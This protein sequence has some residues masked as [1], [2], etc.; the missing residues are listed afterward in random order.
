MNEIRIHMHD[1]G[2]A[3]VVFDDPG[4]TVNVMT[5]DL[6]DAF[7]ANVGP[8]VDD[9]AV[10]AVV[11][12]SAK[13]DT[14]IA[15]A[16]IKLFSRVEDP[17][18]VTRIDR[19]YSNLLTRLIRGGKPVV[20]AVHGAALG[21]GMEVVLACHYILASDDPSTV[22][23]LPEVQ[24]GI[25]P[26]AG[27]TQRLTRRVGLLKGI[28]MMLAGQRVRAGK[29]LELGLVDEIA[30]AGEIIDRAM[31]VARTL[32]ESNR[33]FTERKPR[34]MDRIISLPIIRN[35]VFQKV[36]QEVLKAT[37]GCYP[38]PMKVVECVELGVRRGMDAAL[39]REISHIGN[40]FITPQCRSLVWLFLASREMKPPGEE[41]RPV[42]RAAVLGAGKMGADIASAMLAQCP[43]TVVDVAPEA[44]ESCKKTIQA[45]LDKQVTSG[46]ITREESTRR[47]RGVIA[48]GDMEAIA[49]ADL[50]IV[51][52]SEDL[53]RERRVLA[54]AEKIISDKT[55]FASSAS[56]SPLSEI[57][58]NARAPERVVGMR[59]FPPAHK[60]PLLELVNGA[61][62]DPRALE[63][64]R[65]FAMAQG[66][67][68]IQVKDAPGFYI[69]RILTPW[70]DEALRLLAEGARVEAV[71]RAMKDFGFFSGP[72]DFMDEM[73]LPAAARAFRHMNGALNHRRPHAL[74]ILTGLIEA[75]FQG[76]ENGR[77][78]Y[79]H[80]AGKKG[81]KRPNPGI[82]PHFSPPPGAP[83]TGEQ[84]QNRL[85][86]AMVN[87]AARTLQE[88]V[89]ASPADGDLGAV[90]GLGFPP[91]RAG[92]F[93]YMD[94]EGPGAVAARLQALA[95]QGAPRFRP[96]RILKDM[97]RT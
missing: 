6:L 2:V 73:G 13:P 79:I 35:M 62:V 40:L 31:E 78:F 7:E 64:A 96:A 20:A 30:P 90:L 70:L 60:A 59:Y 74:P 76:R 61:P 23:G 51:A 22:M 80:P 3:K 53:E 87:E 97:A 26:A 10:K 55:V 82:L 58:A 94:A 63:T 95:E 46:A 68:V 93:H 4:R 43:V 49:G 83:P 29:A 91:F 33:S 15:G 14:F 56:L 89:I 42:K 71:D 25:M 18:V 57:A 1:D 92:P 86:L 69:T 27:G 36:R 34:F 72:L 88:E 77:G 21:G 19:G 16:D 5:P 41:A 32:T 38:G 54:E 11:L 28:R 24:L 17:D 52:V 12:T 44:L 9:P 65:A 8:L 85:T 84:I 37:R 81:K 75:G 48:A 67:T 50:V 45:G 39:E 66:K 47:S